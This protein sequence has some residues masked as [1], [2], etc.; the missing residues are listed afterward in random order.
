MRR[1]T[2]L[3]LSPQLAFPEGRQQ[4]VETQIFI[5]RAIQSEAKLCTY[6]CLLLWSVKLHLLSI[7]LKLQV[8]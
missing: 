1:S 7:A 2:V 4:S 6:T 8:D 5:F 3:S